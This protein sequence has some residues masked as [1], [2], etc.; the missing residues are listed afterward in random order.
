MK[1]GQLNQ[2]LLIA[3][4]VAVIIAAFV[5]GGRLLSGNSTEPEDKQLENLPQKPADLPPVS[6]EE[7]AA[8]PGPV[9]LK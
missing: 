3:L 6:E 5:W 9:D 1:L 8:V 7:R 4:V 2:G